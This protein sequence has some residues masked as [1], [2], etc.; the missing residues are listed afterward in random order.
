[1]NILEKNG[2]PLANFSVNLQSLYQVPGDPSQLMLK[3]LVSQGERQ[4]LLVVSYDQ[5]EQLDLQRE[6][7]GC[8]YL[9][10]GAK[11]GIAKQNTVKCGFGATWHPDCSEAEQMKV[12]LP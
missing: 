12:L 10:R 9:V 2:E 8:V 6:I 1:M 4:Q 5:L 7:P 11:S 3:L